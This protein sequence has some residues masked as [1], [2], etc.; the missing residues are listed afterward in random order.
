MR[1]RA[2]SGLL[3]KPIDL[4]EAP[5]RGIGASLAA[6]PDNDDRFAYFKSEVQARWEVLD[7]FFQLDNRQ[8][9]IWEQRAKALIMRKFGIRSDDP[10]WWG[11]FAVQM[12]TSEL[13]GFALQKHNRRK[14]GAPREWTNERLAEWFADIEYLKRTT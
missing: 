7:E 1:Q 12:A 13:P 9:D 8:S 4:L 6:A 11:R 3:L 10:N 5:S 2:F 14:R